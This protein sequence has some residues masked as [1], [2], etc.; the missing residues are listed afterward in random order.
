[1]RETGEIATWKPGIKDYRNWKSEDTAGESGYA[2][3]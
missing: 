2:P 3:G 1:M